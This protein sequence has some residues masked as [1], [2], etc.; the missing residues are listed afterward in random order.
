[1]T[2]KFWRQLKVLSALK[3]YILQQFEKA[4][5]NFTCEHYGHK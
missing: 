1:M 4:N 5:S 2:L 3:S